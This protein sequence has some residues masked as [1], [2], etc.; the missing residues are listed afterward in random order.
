MEYFFRNEIHLRLEIW[1]FFGRNLL[2]LNA[3]QRTLKFESKGRKNPLATGAN[4]F[5]FGLVAFV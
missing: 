3:L 1:A 4:V 5:P 2:P